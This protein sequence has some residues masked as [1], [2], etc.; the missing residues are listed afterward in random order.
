[1]GYTIVVTASPKDVARQKA[2]GASEV[3][4]YRAPDV[5]DQL[6]RLGPYKYIFN[7]TGNPESQAAISAV[8]QPGGGSYASVLPAQNLP[9]N[10]KAIY[11]TFSMTAQEEEHTD[12]RDWW[13]GDYLPKAVTEGK[14]EPPRSVKRQGGLAALQQ[15]SRDVFE[16]KVKEKVVIDPSEE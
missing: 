1:V 11:G 8:L 15:A 10:V 6:Q 3:I 7:A 9:E 16:G 12:F 4:D 13:Y 5:V 14:I 2:I